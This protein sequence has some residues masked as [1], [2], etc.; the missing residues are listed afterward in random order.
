MAGEELNLERVLGVDD[1]DDELAAAR[2]RVEESAIV[3]F[4]FELHHNSLGG[5]RNS[6][7][8]GVETRTANGKA[9]TR[10]E[11]DKLVAAV[12]VK[13]YNARLVGG[14]DKVGL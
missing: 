12:L 9:A 7:A 11:L 10:D 8:F 5:D 1:L 13:S 14:S 6:L 2:R 4:S 3:L